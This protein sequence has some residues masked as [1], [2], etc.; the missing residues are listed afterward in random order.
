MKTLTVRI[1]A[2]TADQTLEAIKAFLDDGWTI[3]F[4]IDSIPVGHPGF[5]YRSTK[6]VALRKDGSDE[7]KHLDF[8]KE[9][10]DQIMQEHKEYRNELHQK[11]LAELAAWKA[12]PFWKRFPFVASKCLKPEWYHAHLD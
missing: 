4:V 11:H 6:E 5:S 10:H 7:H 2:S 9:I 8:T 12:L 1:V 3:M